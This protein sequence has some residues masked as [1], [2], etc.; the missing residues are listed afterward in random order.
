MKPGTTTDLLLNK[1]SIPILASFS[2]VCNPALTHHP[3]F[4]IRVL[5]SLFVFIGPG[6]YTQ[7]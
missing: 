6:N 5:T 7:T 1:A 3:C 4:S 2:G